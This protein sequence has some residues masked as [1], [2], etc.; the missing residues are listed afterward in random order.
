[1]KTESTHHLD[2]EELLAAVDDELLDEKAQSHLTTCSV[3]RSEAEHWTAVALGVRRLANAV[4]I[5]SAALF[6]QARRDIRNPVCLLCRQRELT[7]PQGPADAGRWSLSPWLL[8]SR[9]V[10]ARTA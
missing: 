4:R 9:S 10:P 3:C 7:P 8:C 6:D 2:I 5:P 1:M